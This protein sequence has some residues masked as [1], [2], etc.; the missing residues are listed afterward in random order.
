MLSRLLGEHDRERRDRVDRSLGAMATALTH[1]RE[2]RARLK[3]IIRRYGAASRK[4]YPKFAKDRGARGRAT[5][6]GRTFRSANAIQ[7]ALVFGG[8]A[9]ARRTV[10][11]SDE[12]GD[13]AFRSPINRRSER[14]RDGKTMP[15][16]EVAA[17]VPTILCDLDKPDATAAA[18]ICGPGRGHRQ[19]G[20]AIIVYEFAHGRRPR[21]LVYLPA[22]RFGFPSDIDRAANVRRSGRAKWGIFIAADLRSTR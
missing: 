9:Q 22:R 11:T 1:P 17:A 7:R 16:R 14:P 6:F 8:R 5:V 10:P 4:R 20:R 2:R 21:G 15:F 12:E 19:R 13:T 18:V 3:S